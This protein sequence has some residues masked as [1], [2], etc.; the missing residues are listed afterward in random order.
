MYKL[1][2]TFETGISD[3]HELIST[4]AKSGS[5]KGRPREKIYRS[6]RSLNIETFKKTLRD[7]LSRLE[8]NSYSE[9]EKAFFL[10]VL[11]KPAPLKSTFLR[12][13]NSPFM[14]KELRRAI[15]E[16]SQ[17]KNRYNNNR[18]YENWYWY[19]FKEQRNF[20]ESFLRKT[21]RNYFKNVKIQDITD[22]EKFW[23]TIRPYFTDK[24]YN[25]TKTTVVEKDSIITDGKKKLQ[26]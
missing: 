8:S 20:C 14:T 9:F 1:S 2:N 19:L 13:N 11:N 25:Q 18:N 5:F 22:N 10:T 4:V 3:H 23:K 16:I 12:Q 6:Y 15:M 26:L 24:E 7:K 21:K 17:L